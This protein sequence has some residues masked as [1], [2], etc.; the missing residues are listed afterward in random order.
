MSVDRAPLKRFEL[1]ENF[2]VTEKHARHIHHFGQP[3]CFGMGRERDELSGVD[4][5]AAV[6][7]HM[8]RRYA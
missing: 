4:F 2:R 5:A 3:Q 8:S 7:F 6:G 1:L